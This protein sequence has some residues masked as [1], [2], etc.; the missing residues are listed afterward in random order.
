MNNPPVVRRQIL[1]KYS[2]TTLDFLGLHRAYNTRQEVA[3][4][5]LQGEVA[6]GK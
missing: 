2:H 6:T 5:A 4:K 3:T 1:S